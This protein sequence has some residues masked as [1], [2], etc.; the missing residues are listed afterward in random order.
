MRRCPPRCQRS[1]ASQATTMRCPAGSC[2][3]SCICAWQCCARWRWWFCWW[4]GAGVWR[5]FPDLRADAKRERRIVLRFSALKTGLLFLPV[6]VVLTVGAQ[7]AAHLLGKLGGRPVAVVG[8]LLTAAG[9]ALLTQISSDDN[10]YAAALPGLLLA[11][12]GIGPLFVTATATT[13]ANVGQHEAG[14]ASGVIN[15]FHELGGSIGV[16]VVSTVAA[17]SI[18]NRSAGLGGFSNAYLLCA[19]A[20][21]A[22][23]IIAA[24]LVPAGKQRAVVGHGH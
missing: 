13:L 20:A 3:T 8:L 14:V 1:L 10:A 11:A 2:T 5:L 6:A 19:I 4:L 12:L 7:L 24:G 16:A 23:A 17:S 22:A 18:S 15:T 9:A 21:L